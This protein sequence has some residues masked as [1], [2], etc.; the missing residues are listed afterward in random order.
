MGRVLRPAVKTA[1]KGGIVL[2]R[3]AIA[4]IG[5]FASDIAEEVR[6]ELEEARTELE[7]AGGGQPTLTTPSKAASHA[8]FESRREKH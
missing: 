5:E 6:S 4:E 2:Y 1:L 7:H 3:E 8:R